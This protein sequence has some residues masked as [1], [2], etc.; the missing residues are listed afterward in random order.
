MFEETIPWDCCLVFYFPPKTATRATTKRQTSPLQRC[1]ASASLHWKL[2]S[3]CCTW[4]LKPVDFLSTWSSMT[5]RA[6]VS[7][8]TP[9]RNKTAAL[10]PRKTV[11]HKIERFC[12]SS[13]GKQHQHPEQWQMYWYLHQWIKKAWFPFH[14][15]RILYLDHYFTA[16]DTVFGL[17][18]EHERQHHSVVWFGPVHLEVFHGST[19]QLLHFVV[20]SRRLGVLNRIQQVVW[21]NCNKHVMRDLFSVVKHCLPCATRG[22][23]GQDEL[24]YHAIVVIMDS[25]R[26]LTRA[27]SKQ[28]HERRDQILTFFGNFIVVIDVSRGW[29]SSSVIHWPPERCKSLREFWFLDAQQR[30]AATQTRFL[31]HTQFRHR[32]LYFQT[33]WCGLRF[34]WSTCDRKVQRQSEET[35]EKLNTLFVD[36]VWIS[37]ALDLPSAMKSPGGGCPAK[38]RDVFNRGIDLMEKTVVCLQIPNLIFEGNNANAASVF[39]N[40]PNIAHTY[41]LVDAISSE[42]A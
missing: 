13:P 12:G 1:L 40:N 3:K 8:R 11:T 24:S 4:E 10:S 42:F 38:W 34:F 28:C 18:K 31:L 26:P 9:G 6:S 14:G 41:C 21:V 16:E 30:G 36:T 23:W 27:Q 32:S 22:W 35:P 29:S 37:R 7:L 15:R 39:L 25:T 19:Q 33:G 2:P 20:I 17:G 5:H